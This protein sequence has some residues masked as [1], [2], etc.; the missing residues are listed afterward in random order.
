MSAVACD[1]PVPSGICSIDVGNAAALD[2]ITSIFQGCCGTA[3]VAQWQATGCFVWCPRYDGGPSMD[4]ISKCVSG[5]GSAVACFGSNVATSDVF[6]L[7]KEYSQVDGGVCA[8]CAAKNASQ[9]QQSGSASSTTTP[10][11]TNT[12]PRTT[13]FSTTAPTGSPTKQ[14]TSTSTNA[15]QPMLGP[16]GQWKTGTALF[17]LLGAPFLFGLA[18]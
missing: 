6:N 1:T 8:A 16:S 7:A 5:N 4:D 9:S 10:S 2:N 12:D 14:A 18:F 17:G 13:P 15:A 3:P 11:A